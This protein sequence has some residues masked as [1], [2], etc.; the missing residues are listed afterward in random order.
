MKKW[1]ILYLKKHK[2]APSEKLW[3]I[4]ES[5]DEPNKA[6]LTLLID[7]Y[8]EIISVKPHE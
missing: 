2:E 6:S 3:M 7:G 1:M 5:E 4:I 8:I